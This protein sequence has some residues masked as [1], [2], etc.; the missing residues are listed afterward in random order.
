MLGVA[1]DITDL[2]VAK[3]ERIQREAT[4]NAIISSIPDPIFVIDANM[5]P[6]IFNKEFYNMADIGSIAYKEE[7]MDYQPSNAESRTKR[8]RE[9]QTRPAAA[10][11]VPPAQSLRRIR[12]VYYFLRLNGRALLPLLPLLL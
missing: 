1:T 10:A 2:K 6:I 5:K 4:L 3:R 12:L 9:S 7:I 11:N 8:R